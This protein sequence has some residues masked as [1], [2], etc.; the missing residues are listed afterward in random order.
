MWAT[1]FFKF[2]T[3]SIIFRFTQW[4]SKYVLFEKYFDFV[5]KIPSHKD[6]VL[7]QQITPI[8]IALTF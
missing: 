3:Y 5:L 7:V 2:K 6:Q 1:P 4:T 8:L